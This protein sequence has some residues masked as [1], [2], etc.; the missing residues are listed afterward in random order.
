M[1]YLGEEVDT[2]LV[3]AD[4]DVVDVV[5]V[6]EDAAVEK[7]DVS[8]EDVR[9]LLLDEDIG[10]G[11]M[12]ARRARSTRLGVKRCTPVRHESGCL[13]ACTTREGDAL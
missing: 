11:M 13:W 10:G 8:A 2:A 7:K 5:D 9:G 1:G 4:V 12:C 6:D 3:D